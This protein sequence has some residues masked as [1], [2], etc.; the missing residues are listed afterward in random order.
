MRDTDRLLAN[1]AEYVAIVR[2]AIESFANGRNAAPDNQE[3][4]HVRTR[5]L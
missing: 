1:E 4:V 2:E 3:S 5:A